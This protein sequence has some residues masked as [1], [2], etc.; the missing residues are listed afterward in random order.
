MAHIDLPEGFAGPR[1]PMTLR[2]EAAKPLSELAEV[3]LRG[4]STLTQAERELIGTYVSSQNDCRYCQAILR[5]WRTDRSQST[6]SSGP[7]RS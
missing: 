1:G 2:P 6:P 7:G 3:L 4:P 5:E